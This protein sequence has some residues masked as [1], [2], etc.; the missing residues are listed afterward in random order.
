MKIVGL[1][2]KIR[3]EPRSNNNSNYNKIENVE[4]QSKESKKEQSLIEEKNQTSLGLQRTKAIRQ[5]RI[6]SLLMGGNGESLFSSATGTGT[7]TGTTGIAYDIQRRDSRTNSSNSINTSSSNVVP[8]RKKSAVNESYDQLKNTKQV[9][10]SYIVNK[11]HNDID[12]DTDTDN[13]TLTN[14][15][16]QEEKKKKKKKKVSTNGNMSSTSNDG[17]SGMKEKEIKKKKKKQ[18]KKG[19]LQAAANPYATTTRNTR[20]TRNT[21]TGSD[22]TTT[23]HSPTTTRNNDESFAVGDRVMKV[24]SIIPYKRYVIVNYLTAI[25]DASHDKVVIRPI[26]SFTPVYETLSVTKVV[27]YQK[28][29]LED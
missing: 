2:R 8:S 21:G 17:S 26:A 9:T 24:N 28:K 13:T 25:T 16:K 14:S 29:E 12:N 1:S 23:T 11:S 15:T 4:K 3:Y 5:A 20:N 10:R 27:R 7:G 6:K 18:E 22:T 19:K